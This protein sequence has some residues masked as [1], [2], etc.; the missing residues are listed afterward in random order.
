MSA[1]QLEIVTAILFHEIYRPRMACLAPTGYGKSEAVAM[2]VILRVYICHEPFIIASVKYGTSEIIMKK[3]IEHIFDSDLLVAELEIDTSKKLS[4]LK[5]ERNKQAINFK[6]GGGIK[7]VSLHG[8]E[9]DVSAAIGEHVPNVILDE[10]PLLTAGKYLIVLKMLEGTGDYYR[11]FLFELGNAINRN[12]FM[13][14]IKFNPEYYK[15]DISLEQ[16]L[17]EGRLDEKSVEEKRGLPNFEEFYLCRFPA[18]DE[19]DEN[20]YR[21]LLTEAEIAASFVDTLHVDRGQQIKLGVD[22]GGG[23][24]YNVYCGRQEMQ[25]WI[26]SKN[27]SNDTMVNVSEVEKIIEDY[28][29]KENGETRPLITPN[30]VFLDDI[31]IGRGATDR[32]IEKELEVNGIS[33]G[34]PA[35]DPTRF[36]NKKAEN[37]WRTR[38][39]I[40]N[41]GRLLASKEWYQL[42]WIKYKTNSDKVIQIEPKE[43]L[44]KRTG[45]SP[46]FA[47]ALMLTFST[48]QPVPGIRM[49]D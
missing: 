18:E 35:D 39:F 33:V 14:N 49:L 12:H 30:D 22:I 47:E 41:G 17:A 4:K 13:H 37:Y 42:A 6:S 3:V 26:E 27:K 31:G 25:A 5:R 2:G 43:D 46:D 40:K 1:G 28:T 45:K 19:I 48:P 9:S 10:S 24:D 20:G 34:E 15:L 32:L 23:G 8:S 38:L 29:L 21:Q 36:K 44:K 16:A 7:I 11:T